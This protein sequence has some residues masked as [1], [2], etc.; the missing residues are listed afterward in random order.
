MQLASPPDNGKY[1]NE[2]AELAS[3]LIFSRLRSCPLSEQTRLT[4]VTEYTA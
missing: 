1:E 2:K 3:G 4:A